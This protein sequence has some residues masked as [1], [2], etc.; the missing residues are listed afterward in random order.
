MIHPVDFRPSQDFGANPTKHLPAGHPIIQAFGNYQPDGH[1]GI[2]YPCPV[3]TPVKAAAAGTV[4]HVGRLTGTY[5][6][7]PWWI[8]P[9]FAG[10]TYVV[11]HGHFIGIYGHC[12]DG[13]AKVKKDDRVKEGQVLGLSGNTGA[14]TGPHLHFECL[15]DGY[16]LNSTHYGRINPHTLFGSLSYAGT[17]TTEDDMFSDE[18]RA[19]LRAA[20]NKDDGNQIRKDLGYQNETLFSKA[21]GAWQN[22]ILADISARLGSTLSKEDG[23]Y[24]V[25][26]LEAV[27]PGNTDAGAIAEAVVQAVGKDI[28]AEVVKSIS[29]KLGA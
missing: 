27:K 23:G 14:S 15:P 2:D 7:N 9:G 5:A 16:V 26:L 8:A 3:G 28:A 24:I 11:D 19:L 21:D 29:A 17:T 6:S 13:G 22:G 1:T 12:M 18:D 10:F 4:V 20:L 25:G